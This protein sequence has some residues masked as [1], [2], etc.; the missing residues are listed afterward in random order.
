MRINWNTPVSDLMHSEDDFYGVRGENIRY[1]DLDEDEIM[2]WKYIKRVKL[3]NGKWR[4]IYDESELKKL[5]DTAEQL[6]DAATT[7]RLR[8]GAAQVNLEMHD[9]MATSR[10]GSVTGW[11]QKDSDTHKDLKY[12]WYEAVDRANQSARMAKAIEKAYTK[13]KIRSFAERTISK[14]IVAIANL[15]SDIS[16]KAKRKKAVKERAEAEE[17]RKQAATDRA[18]I[19]RGEWEKGKFSYAIAKENA[20]KKKAAEERAR[21]RR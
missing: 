7:D 20:N 2:H 13:K 5:G 21:R 11:T 14:G 16:Y 8:A 15:I 1:I 3:P 12:E 18:K 17:I 19:A 9:R 10:T 6:R 4:Y